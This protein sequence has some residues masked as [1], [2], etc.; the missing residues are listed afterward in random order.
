MSFLSVITNLFS[1]TETEVVALVVDIK[2]GVS[3]AKAD[4]SKAISWLKTNAP[5]IES[6]LQGAVAIVEELGVASN[7]DVALAVTAAN[8]TVTAL[9]AFV[10]A[11]QAGASNPQAVVQGYVA[12]KQAQATAASAAAA[13]ASSTPTK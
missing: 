10:A 7:P 6:D 12:Y 3:V 8:A 11:S 13:A 4:L 1:D 9:N 2:K 5:T